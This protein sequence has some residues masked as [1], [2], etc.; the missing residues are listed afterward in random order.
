MLP[1]RVGMDGKAL[2]ANVPRSAQAA[3]DAPSGRDP[4]AQ[5]SAVFATLLP[6]LRDLRIARMTR[7]PFAFLRGSAAL[8]AADLATTPSTGILAQISGDAHLANFGGYASPERRL[9]FDVNDFDESVRGPWEWDLKRLATSVVLAGMEHGLRAAAYEPAVRRAVAVYRDRTAS[10]AALPVLDRWY[11]QLS[12]SAAMRASLD[13]RARRLWQRAARD[14][15]SRTTLAL[16]P[17]IT[18]RTQNQ[19]RFTDAPPLLEHL[20]DGA[21]GNDL[22]ERI[23]ETYR[24]S[25]RHDARMLLA[26]FRVVDV[27]RKVVGVGSVGTWCALVLLLDTDGNPLLLQLKE[28]RASALEPYVGAQPYATHGE[29]VVAGQRMMQATSDALLGWAQVDERSLYVRQY[30][31]MKTSPDLRALDAE[32]LADVAAHCAWALARAHARTGDPRAVAA[33]VGRGE[34]FVDAIAAFARSYAEQVIHD[35]ASFVAV[36][37]TLRQPA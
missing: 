17:S 4:L 30:R 9:V 8:M 25:L 10:Y 32:A 31:D 22:A 16:L 2:R 3:W 33:Y 23:L 19:L 12:L 6:D 34:V 24:A 14:A 20:D 7:S 26:R 1:T 36:A 13:P 18:Q 11:A 5:L 35:H 27:V 29:R 28:A 21:H 37:H 15:R